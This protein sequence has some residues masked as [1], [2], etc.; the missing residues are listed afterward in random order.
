MSFV[1]TYQNIYI[2]NI[3]LTLAKGID[4]TITFTVAHQRGFVTANFPKVDLFIF[5]YCSTIIKYSVISA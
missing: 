1:K 5:H 4:A 3:L 2:T